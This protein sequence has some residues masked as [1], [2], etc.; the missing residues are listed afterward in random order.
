MDHREIRV[1]VLTSLQEI[2]SVVPEWLD[3]WNR[4]PGA[5]PFQAPQ[6]LLPWWKN[7]GGGPLRVLAFRNSRRLAAFAPLFIH[8]WPDGRKRRVAWIGSGISDHLD[9]LA[10][11]SFSKAAAR[12]LFRFLKEDRAEWDIVDLQELGSESP[13]LQNPESGAL[14][15]RILN[16]EVCPVLSLPPSLDVFH[17]GLDRR[18]KRGVARGERRLNE[19]G[20]LGM[21]TATA[22][23]LPSALNDLFRLHQACWNAKKSPGV[24]RDPA[25]RRFHS[26]AAAAFLAGGHLRLYSLTAA[27]RTIASLYTLVKGDRV[28]GYLGGFDPELRA[29]SPGSVLL[30]RVLEDC[31]R[32]SVREFDFLR[33]AEKY[34]YIWG[35]VDRPNY[36]LVLWHSPQK[37]RIGERGEVG[38]AG[39]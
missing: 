15:A 39:G 27:G 16:G 4:I 7:L 6:W 32:R 29:L 19:A 25:L 30:R 3:L 31:I 37:I 38:F 11:P 34:K 1:D 2:E 17:A 12:A 5:T 13:L 36:R 23:D 22:A 9:L 26:E 8:T 33:G 18:Q 35:A 14:R 28:Y 21:K 24:L 10:E 20:D